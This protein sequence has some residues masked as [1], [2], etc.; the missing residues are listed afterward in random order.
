MKIEGHRI[1]ITLF[2]AVFIVSGYLFYTVRS[3]QAQLKEQSVRSLSLTK[4]NLLN[5]WENY[6]VRCRTDTTLVHSISSDS[7]L[8]KVLSELFGQM[9]PGDFFDIT[10]VADSSGLV[11]VSKPDHPVINMPSDK[12]FE[13]S[14]EMILGI[15][16]S[17]INISTEDYQLFSAPVSLEW[18]PGQCMGINNTTPPESRLIILHGA[19]DQEKLN[20][21]GWQIPFLAV[22][23]LLSLLIFILVSY[24]IIRIAGMG[25]GDTLSGS[26]V[27]QTGLSII[28]LSVF[29]GFSIS[30]F[31]NRS[32]IKKEQQGSVHRLSQEIEQYHQNQ[33]ETY[34]TLLD[35]FITHGFQAVKEASP[36]IYYKELL[37]ININGDILNMWLFDADAA[38]DDSV[39][40]SLPNLADRHYFRNAAADTFYH[41]SHFSYTDG[42]QEG[43]ISKKTAI[44]E[45]DADPDSVFVH[46]VTYSFDDFDK[47]DLAD[48]NPM[49]LKY[50]ILNERGDVYYQSPY[51]NTTISSVEDVVNPRQWHEI[52]ALMENNSVLDDFLKVRVSFEGQLFY[53]HLQRLNSGNVNL[54]EPA[55]LLAF[56][57]PN[58]IAFRSYSIFM[59]AGVG[60]FFLVIVFLTVALISYIFRPGGYY[61]SFRRFNE[62]LFRPSQKKGKSYFVLN[63]II[64]THLLFFFVIILILDVHHFWLF[65]L[66]FSLTIVYIALSRHLLLSDFLKSPKKPDAWKFPATIIC[67]AL[68][69]LLF[70]YLTPLFSLTE[71]LIPF[72]LLAIQGGWLL[73]IFLSINRSAFPLQGQLSK[74]KWGASGIHHV[75]TFIS[76]PEEMY[77]C[78]FAFWV[79]LVGMVSG[80]TIHHSASH[81][82]GKLWEVAAEH[83]P[84]PHLPEETETIEHHSLHSV[85]ESLFL[86]QLEYW[87]RQWLINYSGIGYPVIN[88]YIYARKKSFHDAFQHEDHN[89]TENDAEGAV[90]GKGFSEI[91]LIVFSFLAGFILLYFLV[92]NL[93]RRIFLTHYWDFIPENEII[94]ET[95]DQTYLLT[96][97]HKKALKLLQRGFL[98]NKKYR[99]LDLSSRSEREKLKPSENPGKNRF[100]SLLQKNEGIVLLNTDRALV[101]SGNIDDITDLI[102]ICKETDKFVIM[103][104]SK[105]IKELREITP[106]KED[107][108]YNYALLNWID[109][110][111]SFITKIIPIHYTLEKPVRISAAAENNY[112][113]ELEREIQYGPHSEKLSLLLQQTVNNT[114]FNKFT[115][116]DYEAF[117]L[118]IQ[119]HNKSYYQNLWDNLSFRE[120][121]MVYNF[122]NEGFVNYSNIDVLTELLQKGIFRMDQGAEEIRLFN[123]SFCNFATQAATQQLTKEFKKDKRINGNVSHLRNALL[124][125]IFLSILVISLFAPELPEQYIGAISGG[126][127][128]MSSLASVAGKL[129]INIPFLER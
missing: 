10:I 24:P 71:K 87:R 81:F 20:Q 80:Y 61:L 9:P 38:E 11:L 128:V 64:L 127:A 57:D 94:G 44:S 115:K 91:I 43:V 6:Q 86:N 30:Y 79:L 120:K 52:K 69:I 75:K 45:E 19:I 70:I 39:I 124:T 42:K 119:R 110:T 56:D 102:T 41:G 34:A 66:L 100:E 35:R 67:L 14:E 113:S 118:N 98:K 90:H 97:D 16:Q 112:I 117:I 54:K 7:D 28:L 8:K 82:E 55:W 58:L 12:R 111:S 25:R 47:A 18:D 126:L 78:T 85:K 26:Q 65:I 13:N 76:K 95:G 99:V 103:T 101:S 96:L 121:Q 106:Q 22:Y 51:V 62:F 93:S 37:E 53:A 60:Y 21:A 122:A 92:K 83:H 29:I 40:A 107:T 123:L 3:N 72:I 46:A 63:L 116:R 105:S 129:S 15:I 88:Q 32:E 89:H 4:N 114:G 108:I 125:I 33:L 1:W 77:A 68:L 74:S 59:Y 23:F 31:V 17:K 73:F 48:M 50:L 36:A 49:G 84:E 104:G 109:A 2:L 5:S 27:Y